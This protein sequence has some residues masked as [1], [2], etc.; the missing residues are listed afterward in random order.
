MKGVVE[1][2]ETGTSGE[3]S[4][5]DVCKALSDFQAKISHMLCMDVKRPILAEQ[6]RKIWEIL[7]RCSASQSS[8]VRV[9]TYSTTSIFLLKLVPFVPELLRDTFGDATMAHA[10]EHSSSVLVVAVFSFLSHFVSPVRL[11]K[12]LE[13]TQIFHQF[14]CQESVTSQHLSNIVNNLGNLSIEWFQ[15]LLL[16]LFEANKAQESRVVIKAIATVVKRNPAVLMGCLLERQCPLS[17]A[18]YLLQTVEIDQQKVDLSILA[19]QAFDVLKDPK[20]NKPISVVDDAF[21]VLSHVESQKVRVKY[22]EGIRFEIE[23]E[24]YGK[25]EFSD[26]KAMQRPGFYSLPLPHQFLVPKREDSYAV[27]GAKLN[28]LG[29]GIRNK[30]AIMDVEEEIAIFDQIA[31]YGYDDCTPAVLQ[32]LSLCVNCL[33]QN[34][35]SSR[36]S[37]ILRRVLFC[38]PKSWF[39]ASDILAVIREIDPKLISAVFGRSG[40][41]EL[42][43]IVLKFCLNQND[44]LS[45]SSFQVISNMTTE[46]TFCEVTQC[47]ADDTDFFDSF[48]LQKHLLILAGLIKA[49]F[50]YNRRH[51]RSF[52]DTILEVFPYHS[53]DISVLGSIYQ[54]LAYVDISAYSLT[55]LEDVFTTAVAVLSATMVSLGGAKKGTSVAENVQQKYTEIVKKYLKNKTVEV[56]S[57]ESYAYRSHFAC[58]YSATTF[59]LNLPIGFVPPKFALAVCTHMFRYFPLECTQFFYSRYE[60]YDVK[61]HTN[62][63]NFVMQN[64]DAVD[65]PHVYADWCRIALLTKMKKNAVLVEAARYFLG[66]TDGVKTGDLVVFGWFLDMMHESVDPVCAMLKSTTPERQIE[67]ARICQAA[68][69]IKF[70][71]PVASLISEI[72]SYFILTKSEYMANFDRLIE[73]QRTELIQAILDTDRPDVSKLPESA[74]KYSE[75]HLFGWD[76]V[77]FNTIIGK[78]VDVERRAFNPLF[79]HSVSDLSLQEKLR[80]YADTESKDGVTETLRMASIANEKLDFSGMKFSPLTLPSVISYLMKHNQAQISDVVADLTPDDF[81]TQFRDAATVA[82]GFHLEKFKDYF[83]NTEHITKHDIQCLTIAVQ[84]LLDD[85]QCDK[86]FD[87]L[88]SLLNRKCKSE[89]R[90]SVLFCAIACSIEKFHGIDPTLCEEI[91]TFMVLHQETLPVKQTWMLL[92]VLSKYSDIIRS[93]L[94]FVDTLPPILAMRKVMVHYR[95]AAPDNL[96]DLVKSERPSELC[97]TLQVMTEMAKEGKLYSKNLKSCITTAFDV[98]RVLHDNFAVMEDFGIFVRSVIVNPELPRLQKIVYERYFRDILVRIR[99]AAFL[100]LSVSLPDAVRVLDVKS[101]TYKRLGKFCGTIILQKTSF[102]VFRLFCRTVAG[103]LNRM[104]EHHEDQ[105][106]KALLKFLEVNHPFDSHHIEKYMREW[107]FL[108]DRWLPPVSRLSILSRQFVLGTSRFFPVFVS[109]AHC[110]RTIIE[111]SP[112]DK[113]IVDLALTS[114]AQEISDENHK[115][116]LEKLISG[117][118]IREAIELALK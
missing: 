52:T 4:P 88:R 76:L 96:E 22:L 38:E 20:E 109:I 19:F 73:S 26:E 47:V 5:S 114:A 57:S 60:C 42:L 99:E 67:F 12:F 77:K 59:L 37:N 27:I 112:D 34:S 3:K 78:E 89:K 36:L 90:V 54:F 33:I 46:E 10:A 62:F 31:S 95:P 111:N 44:D 18:A 29:R 30:N 51:L 24:G 61:H 75:E 92:F 58:I 118:P 9:A 74:V 13:K 1:K 110:A 70:S 82:F 2:L 17:L 100:S 23:L 105:L 93:K 15:G 49:N 80:Y 68:A 6:F 53:E 43:Q 56:V 11:D 48:S 71:A 25:V 8:T 113:A 35:K 102:A 7:F 63:F 108:M 85:K 81:R 32:S 14:V 94:P 87:I 64:L 16:A 116:A 91:L 69:G 106:T 115:K 28:T 98:A 55:K 79:T 117:A 97:C 66:H 103:R 65:D 40:F 50:R 83:T 84:K 45:R 104:T 21:M 39:H 86:I 72:A 101:D 107:T 41:R